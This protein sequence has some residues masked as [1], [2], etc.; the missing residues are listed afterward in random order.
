MQTPLPTTVD[1]TY[2]PIWTQLGMNAPAPF[3]YPVD[4]NEIASLSP[5]MS[6]FDMYR[7]MAERQGPS[8]WANLAK[9]SGAAQTANQKELAQQQVSGQTAAAENA[10]ASNGGL[11]SGARERAEE[12]GETNYL[13]MSQNLDRQNNLND[14]QIGINDAQNQVQ[15][16]GQLPTL[17]NQAMQ[18]LYQQANLTA[19]NNSALNAYNQ[20]VWNQ[21]NQAIA[22]SQQANATANSGKK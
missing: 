9:I 2:N 16:L 19:E 3:T 18:P 17:E 15:Q 22:A 7:Q 14:L 1:P 6:G 10:L 21:T 8:T 5:D 20:N 4:P 12:G 11:S 13:D